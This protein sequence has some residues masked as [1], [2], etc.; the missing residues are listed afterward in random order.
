M[1]PNMNRSAWIKDVKRTVLSLKENNFK[2]REIR[3]RLKNEFMHKVGIGETIASYV[4]FVCIAFITIFGMHI[5]YAFL[6][7]EADI[8]GFWEVFS[9][10]FSI[11]IVIAL[12]VVVVAIFVIWMKFFIDYFKYYKALDEGLGE[13]FYIR[14]F[15]IVCVLVLILFCLFMLVVLFASWQISN[16]YNI[17]F[18]ITIFQVLKDIFD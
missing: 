18:D 11:M 1:M 9:P 6:M 17:R 14:L 12:F 16:F 4:L 15:R 3:K 7:W 8:Y 13:S 2:E 10:Y 5:C